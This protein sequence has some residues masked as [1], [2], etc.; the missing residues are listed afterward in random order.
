MYRSAAIPVNHGHVKSTGI[1]IHRCIKTHGMPEID[2][3]EQ[4]TSVTKTTSVIILHES[5]PEP[6][7]LII[8]LF[9]VL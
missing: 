4:T 7:R 3:R 9:F 5:E 6:Q 8:M 2:P 1:H